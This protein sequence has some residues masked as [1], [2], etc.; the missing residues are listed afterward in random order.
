MKIFDT[1]V[2]FSCI[3]GLVC[4]GGEI[5]MQDVM[6]RE[7]SPVPTSMLTDQGEMRT[8]KGNQY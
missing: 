2:I 4:S 8:A 3:V 1:S 7:L 6:N 5:Q